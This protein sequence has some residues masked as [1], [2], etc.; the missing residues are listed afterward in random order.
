MIIQ[1]NCQQLWV[2]HQ[3]VQSTQVY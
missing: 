1:A 3:N 2:E